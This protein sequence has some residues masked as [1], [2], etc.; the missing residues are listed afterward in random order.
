MTHPSP[1]FP[2]TSRRRPS[3]ADPPPPKP[4]CRH[5][6]TR[7]WGN[8]SGKGEK[9]LQCGVELGRQNLQKDF[10]ELLAIVEKN[11]EEV[12][13]NLEEVRASFSVLKEA[14]AEAA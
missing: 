6:L 8:A 7:K 3:S 2:R 10:E 1:R 4:K 13:A 9:C 5:A 14:V 12:A 11:L